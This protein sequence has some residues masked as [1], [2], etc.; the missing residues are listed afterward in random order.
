M[1]TPSPPGFYEAVL[2]QIREERDRV[3]ALILNGGPQDFVTY[4]AQVAKLTTVAWAEAVVV[5][6][7]S[8]LVEDKP[9]AQLQAEQAEQDAT[10]QHSNGEDNG[11]EDASVY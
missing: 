4:R 9:L 8:S 7:W 1:A 11:D 3:A 2:L 5:D 10:A 6:V